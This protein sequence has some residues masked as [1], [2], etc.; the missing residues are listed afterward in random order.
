MYISSSDSSNFHPSNEPHNFV[1]EL[2]RT[3]FGVK[4]IALL[5]FSCQSFTEPL[6]VFCDLVDRSL[7]HDQALAVLRYI[8]EPGEIQNPLFVNTTQVSFNRIAFQVVSSRDMNDAINIGE[9]HL[10]LALE[11]SNENEGE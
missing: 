10:I 9:V 6:Y 8:N 4:R 7:V 3:Y 2:P 1:I 11:D 5:E